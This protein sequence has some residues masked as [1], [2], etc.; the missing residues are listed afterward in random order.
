MDQ[1][2]S[3]EIPGQDDPEL[4]ELVLQHWYALKST[5]CPKIEIGDRVFMTTLFPLRRLIFIDRKL[6]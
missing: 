5:M 6:Q 4:R 1:A 2:V 3:A